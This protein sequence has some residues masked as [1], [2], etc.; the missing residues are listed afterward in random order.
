MS[1]HPILVVFALS[2]LTACGGPADGADS[3]PLDTD[4]FGS[5]PTPP[6]STDPATRFTDRGSL[7]VGF[8]VLEHDRGDLAPLVVKAWYPADAV[9]DEE[10][11]YAVD[12][13]LFGPGGGP[14]PFFGHAALDATPDGASGPFPLVVLSHGFGMNPE[15]YHPL[16]EHLASHGFVVLGPEHTEFD[17]FTDVVPA[18]VARP[19][20]VSQTIDLATTGVLDGVIDPDRVAVL[21]HSYG[22]YTALAVAGARIDLGGLAARCQDVADPFAAA[23]FCDPFLTGEAELAAAMGLDAIPNGQ[24]PSLA[25]DRVDAVLPMAGDA[26]LF[27][28]SGLAEVTVPA[29]LLGGTGDTGTPWDWGA[30]LAFDHIGSEDRWLVAF[31]GAEHFIGV[32]T[33]DHMPWTEGL[34]VEYLGYFCEDPAWDKPTA[35]GLIQQVATAFLLDALTGSPEAATA[36][37]P[38][39]YTDIEG[40]SLTAGD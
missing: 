5:S 27:G 1:R 29:M 15:W 31:E 19:A 21:G 18:T 34:P 2:F 24:W 8:R 32:T 11:T 20:E 26:Y 3:G 9:G 37:V 38:E 25:D 30:G 14:A 35:L 40:F 7:P 10:I 6:G 23:Y 39:L 36:L 12:L 33:C 17:W 4:G 16:A 13:K 22:G 28:A